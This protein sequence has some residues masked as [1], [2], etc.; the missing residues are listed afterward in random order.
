MV[1]KAING[2]K[3]AEGDCIGA[4]SGGRVCPASIH[5]TP[6]PKPASISVNQRVEKA[7]NFLNNLLWKFQW[8]AGYPNANGPVRQANLESY[9]N[10]E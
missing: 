5:S 2:A 7:I 8:I 9:R 4:A 10:G 1:R 3:G 6:P